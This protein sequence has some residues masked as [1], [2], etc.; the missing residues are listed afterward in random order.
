MVTLHDWAIKDE[1][2]ML[3]LGFI[4]FNWLDDPIGVYGRDILLAWLQLRKSVNGVWAKPLLRRQHHSL[5]PTSVAPSVP[6]KRKIKVA[7]VHEEGGLRL[8]FTPP[9]PGQKEQE[10]HNL[11]RVR[12]RRNSLILKLQAFWIMSTCNR[13]TNCMM[14]RSSRWNM[15]SS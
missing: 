11:Y 8:Q 2:W 14:A 1:G 5:C 13:T 7:Y 15:A 3:F 9:G 10:Q 4:V 12:E 6:L